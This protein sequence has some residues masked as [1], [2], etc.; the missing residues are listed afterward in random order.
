MLT[1][2]GNCSKTLNF[3]PNF[4]CHTISESHQL[5][6]RRALLQKNVWASTNENGA[7]QNWKFWHRN[8]SLPKKLNFFFS[9][10]TFMT[11]FIWRPKKK[12]VNWALETGFLEK[13]NLKKAKNEKC[14]RVKCVLNGPKNYIKDW[15]QQLSENTNLATSGAKKWLRGGVKMVGKRTT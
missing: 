4:K 3:G 7:F 6:G 2:S 9:I 15:K 8:F 13:K 11:I 1:K 10:L 12:L 14:A 5:H